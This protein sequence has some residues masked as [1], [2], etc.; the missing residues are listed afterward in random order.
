MGYGCRIGMTAA[1]ETWTHER[2]R[3]A[4]DRDRHACECDRAAEA[5]DRAAVEHDRLR[6]RFSPAN[7][8]RAAADRAWAARD[9][10]RAASDRERSADDREEAARE[11][12]QAGVDSLTGA[13][14]RDRGLVELQR[15]IE[16]AR[17]SD[18]QLV[19][20]F[21]DVDRLK[22]TND[23]RGHAAGD[24]LL[25]DVAVALRTGLRSYDLVV[26]YGGDEFLYALPGI[27]VDGAR[28]RF[29]A[30]TSELTERN[31]GAS[32]SIG[33]A[34]LGDS[35]TLDE[36]IARADESLYAVRA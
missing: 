26:R 6:R 8:A 17:R 18:G 14:R 25:R 5:R 23:L 9:R 4:D 15:E 24:R 12:A 29:D 7:P 35:D 30:V 10:T 32:V 27:D 13:L 28:R 2:D 31:P 3:L 16:R 19:L 11:R 22:A 34:T 20:A 21:V 33:W 36:L 1:N